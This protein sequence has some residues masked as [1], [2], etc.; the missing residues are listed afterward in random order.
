MD[1]P[2]AEKILAGIARNEKRSQNRILAIR[3][4]GILKGWIK[5]DIQDALTQAEA[6]MEGLKARRRLRVNRDSEAAQGKD[7]PG[8][9]P[10]PVS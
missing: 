2:E 1:Q 4:L 3:E 10:G 8:D 5:G 7:G 9:V 6:F